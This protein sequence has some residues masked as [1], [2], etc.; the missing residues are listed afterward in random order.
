MG[1]GCGNSR[2]NRSGEGFHHLG[3]RA[4]I[5]AFAQE[6]AGH[7]H[8]SGAGR[9][10]LVR[11]R[12]DRVVD[13]DPRCGV[14]SVPHINNSLHSLSLSDAGC[15]GAAGRW[16]DGG[17]T[18]GAARGRDRRRSAIGG[19]REACEPCCCRRNGPVGPGRYGR[20]EQECNS[21]G[22]RGSQRPRGRIGKGARYTGGVRRRVTGG[23]SR[24]RAGGMRSCRCCD[25]SRPPGLAPDSVP[26]SG[27]CTEGAHHCAG[28]LSC[29][30]R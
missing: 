8:L 14:V 25:S 5:P 23:N 3:Y 9:R 21:D 2:N 27:S 29:L 30:R 24:S 10:V 20:F 26:G 19:D 4:A 13:G 28:A 16:L 22:G 18:C 6:R 17:E 15:R 11:S 7:G 12:A 1:S